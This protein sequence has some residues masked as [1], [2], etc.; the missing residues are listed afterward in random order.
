MVEKTY[1][2]EPETVLIQYG[3]RIRGATEFRAI[4]TPTTW[5]MALKL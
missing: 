2:P 5:I 3:I 1:G 4:L